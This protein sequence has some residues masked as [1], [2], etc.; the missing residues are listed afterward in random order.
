MDLLRP[1]GYYYLSGQAGAD[2]NRAPRVE[3]LVC[4]ARIVGVSLI[5][6]NLLRSI[7]Q[8]LPL[9]RCVVNGVDDGHWEE[10]EPIFRLILT[11]FVS[12][13]C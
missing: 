7:G 5:C 2:P 11:I 10:C 4:H 3:T 1:S 8:L 6:T 13:L 9:F 12:S